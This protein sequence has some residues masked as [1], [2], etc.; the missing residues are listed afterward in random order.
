MDRKIRDTFYNIMFDLATKVPWVSYD[1]LKT[2][3]KVKKSLIALAVVDMLSLSTNHES[4]R[5]IDGSLLT[6]ENCPDI[7]K[8]MFTAFIKI[9][10][11][12][13]DLTTQDLATINSVCLSLIGL[14]P[15]LF[16]IPSNV[17]TLTMYITTL[18]NEVYDRQIFHDVIELIAEIYSSMKTH[19]L[20]EKLIRDSFYQLMV[21]EAYDSDISKEAFENCEAYIFLDLSAYTLIAACV[22]SLGING[23]RLIDGSVLNKENCP[24]SYKDFTNILLQIKPS[25]SMFSAEHQKNLKK[26]CTSNPDF[27]IDES[28]KLPQLVK[29][30][31]MI[32]QISS[33]IS[34]RETFKNIIGD[35]INFCIDIKT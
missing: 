10:Q 33:K 12:S 6:K 26:I 29:F 19:K 16:G 21:N 25:F 20:S 3:T 17:L 5:L 11:L 30:A 27:V 14:E 28:I 1:K 31:T 15:P 32:N 13:C 2:N 22:S 35:V 4:I 23:I 34:Q 8:E 9:K 24:E 7:F 18:T